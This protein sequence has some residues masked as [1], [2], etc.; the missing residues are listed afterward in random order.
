MPANGTTTDNGDGTITY[1]PASDFNGVDT[2]DY[3]ICD[4]IGACDTATVTITVTPVNDLPVAVDDTATTAEDTPVTIPVLTNDSDLDL[5]SLSVAAVSD[6]PNGS[7]TVN[8]DGT[9]TYNPDADVFG[10]DSFV[11][12]LSDSNGGV[13]F[14][15]VAITVTPVNDAPTV[16]DD[17]ATAAED[18]PVTIP[19]LANDFDVDGTLDPSTVVIIGAPS[20]GGTAA[21]PNGSIDYLPAPNFNGVDT[22]VYLVCDNN[23]ACSGG[24]VT[25]TVAQRNDAPVLGAVGDRAVDELTD[26]SIG[27][28]AADVDGDVMSFGLDDGRAGLVPTGATIDPTTGVFSWRPSEVQGPGVYT[29]D[30]VVTDDGSPNLTDAETITITVGEVNAAPVAEGIPT[31]SVVGSET[32]LVSPSASDSDV[33]VQS[34]VWR[35]LTGPGTVLPDGSYYWATRAADGPGT[36]AVTLE[37]SDGVATDAVSFDVNIAEPFVP[38]P[39]P[40][41]NREPIANADYVVMLEDAEVGFAPLANDIDPEGGPLSLISWDTPTVGT[42]QVLP[43]GLVRYQPPPNF[44]GAVSVAYTIADDAGATA[45]GLIA[46]TVVPVNDAPVSRPDSASLNSYDPVTIAVLDNDSDVDGDSVSIVAVGKP[47]HGKVRQTTGGQI[48]YDPDSGWTGE[49][50]FTYTISDSLGVTATTTVS[51]EVTQTALVTGKLRATGLGVGAL[52]LVIPEPEEAEGLS[53]NLLAVEGVSLLAASFWQTVLALQIPLVFLLLSLGLVFFSGGVGNVLALIAGRRRYYSVVMLGREERLIVYAE[54]NVDSDVITQ[55]LPTTRSIYGAGRPRVVNGVPWTPI[56]LPNGAGWA[57]SRYLVEEMDYET[58]LSD[59]RPARLVDEFVGALRTGGSLKKIVSPRGLAI[60]LS[61]TVTLAESVEL[62]SL[63]I[64]RQRSNVVGGDR[65]SIGSAEVIGRF[66]AAYDAT[67]EVNP[68][69]PHS[70]TALLPSECQNFL[71]LVLEPDATGNPWLVYIEY[72]GR[73]VYVSGL[74]ID[75]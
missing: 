73:N 23:G 55:V 50:H 44:N 36:Y 41:V 63:R 48:I 45:R 70:S 62:A 14:A 29:F 68:R 5:D 11:Y 49:D 35:I 47:S 15:T 6:P 43:N 13:D 64:D 1:T 42:M 19:V 67:G 72:R 22:F 30:I 40:P 75:V 27:V 66:L 32:V 26:L 17:A 2:F 51:L 54:P 10:I 33:P 74:G 31:Q 57:P 71:Y 39:D 65:T 16:V 24:T 60:A 25:V 8:S 58:F 7:A 21:N 52:P 3:E 56:E 69:T 9:I 61:E 12:A 53:L 28:A 34:L 37:V 4:T 18:T 46:I 59:R 38:P 20:N